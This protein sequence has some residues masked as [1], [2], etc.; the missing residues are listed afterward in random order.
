MVISLVGTDFGAWEKAG[1]PEK[2]PHVQADNC[3]TMS[4]TT[5]VDHGDQTRVAVVA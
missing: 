3:Y 4:H 1:V 2:K 5:T